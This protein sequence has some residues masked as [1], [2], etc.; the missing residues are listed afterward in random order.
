MKPATACLNASG[1]ARELGISPKAL[2]LYEQKGLIDPGRSTA[3]YRVYSPDDMAAAARVVSLRALGLS[4][5]QIADVLGGDARSLEHALAAHEQSLNERMQGLAAQVRRLQDL[6]ESLPTGQLPDAS[7]ID[8]ILNES[9]RMRLS[10][11]LPWPWNG[12]CF[13]IPAIHPINYLVGPLGSG[14]TILAHCIAGAFPGS[15][16]ID[17]AQPVTPASVDEEHAACRI[18]ERVDQAMA[19]LLGEG[20]IESPMLASLLRVLE[21][22]MPTLLVIDSIESNLD[23]GSQEA[24]MRYLR[25]QV[26]R[27]SRPLFLITRSAAILDLDRTGA[28]EAIYFCPANHRLPF[29]VLPYRGTAGYESLDDCLATPAER[30][31]TR[32]MRAC[33]LER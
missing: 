23:Q 6:R 28:D 7:D 27:H 26:R 10:M 4:L 20:A 2:R 16:C 24:L 12:E 14:K 22:D 5:A 11:A 18:D 15:I 19:W 3:G 30:E 17:A 25:L 21:S 1:A 32:G 13:D 8:G 9:P 29:R 31:R 33:I